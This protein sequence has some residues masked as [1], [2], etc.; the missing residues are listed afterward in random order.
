MARWKTTLI[1]IGT[2]LAVGVL[3]RFLNLMIAP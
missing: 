1:V 2:V 3:V